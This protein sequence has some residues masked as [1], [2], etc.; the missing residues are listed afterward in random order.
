MD[1]GTMRNSV[2]GAMLMRDVPLFNNE[3][4]K[5]HVPYVML[6]RQIRNRGITD[7]AISILSRNR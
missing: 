1:N 3:I 2:V 4:V 6:K 7:G 5:F